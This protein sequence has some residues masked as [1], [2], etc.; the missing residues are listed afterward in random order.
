MARHLDKYRHV[1]TRHTHKYRPESARKL[2]NLGETGRGGSCDVPGK[3]TI[4]ASDCASDLGLCT[5]VLVDHIVCLDY[6][7]YRCITYDDLHLA[8]RLA[9]CCSEG[10]PPAD[11]H[12]VESVCDRSLSPVGFCGRQWLPCMYILVVVADTH[13]CHVQVCVY[14]GASIVHHNHVQQSCLS[15]LT[16]VVGVYVNV[17]YVCLYM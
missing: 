15:L 11:L 2:S 16:A 3:V 7:T 9:H 13:P 10:M 4:P 6:S 1:Q 12:L 14:V 8:C 5:N 17:V